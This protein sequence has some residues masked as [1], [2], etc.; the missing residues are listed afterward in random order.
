MT[1]TRILLAEDNQGDTNLIMSFC[2]EAAPQLTFT[3]AATAAACR[4]YLFSKHAQSFDALILDYILP[5]TEGL[6]LLREVIHAQYPAPVIIITGRDDAETAVEAMKS[7]AMDYLVKTNNYW[8]YLP[9]VIESAIAR[10][11]LVRENRRLQRELATYTNE[12]EQAVRIVQREQNRLRAVLDQLPEGVIIVEGAEGRVV[13]INHAA[14]R[15]LGA[16]LVPGIRILEY[17]RYL[18]KDLNGTARGPADTAIAHVLR[19]GQPMM[20]EQAVLVGPHGDQHT[21]LGNTA[22]LLDERGA[23]TGAVSVFQDISELKRLERLTDEILSIASHELK[24]PLT[25][26]VGYSALLLRSSPVQHDLRSRRATETIQQQS[27]RMRWLVERLLDLSRLDL[28]RLMLE[29]TGFDLVALLRA[30]AE[31]QQELTKKHRLH[32]LTEHETLT[33]EGDSIRLEQV[34]V[35][36]IN[37]A[38]KYSPNGGEVILSLRVLDAVA[39]PEATCNVAPSGPGPFALVQIRDYGIG[40]DQEAQKKLFTRFYRTNEAAHIAAGQGLGLYVSAE[41]VRLH[42]G[43]LCAQGK[44]GEGSTF[45]LILPLKSTPP[46]VTQDTPG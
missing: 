16:A 19:T 43:A 5:D 29:K 41:I 17:E 46:A 7:G 38:I 18:G 23:V 26:I 34:F 9:R 25:V 39:L 36:L 45:S 3:V 2:A 33:V 35:N 27:Q 28:G 40:I 37:N 22:P 42:G 30:I 21:I 15:L 20:A 44:P 13:A 1:T 6:L 24:N 14:R 10:Y 32:V 4:V 11:R 31:Q 12:L 8:E